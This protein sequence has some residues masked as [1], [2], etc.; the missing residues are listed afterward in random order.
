MAKINI[1]D[2]MLDVLIGVVI[3]VALIGVI[4]SSINKFDWANMNIS[5]TMFDA[6]WAPYI[7]VILLVV[8]LVYLG[9]KMIKR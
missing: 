2:N 7:L 6:S 9:Y 5:G 8:G 3:F 4:V 1:L